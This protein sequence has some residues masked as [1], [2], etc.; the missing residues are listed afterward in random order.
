MMRLQITFH[1]SY[2]N[3]R[4]QEHILM[5]K[6]TLITRPFIFFCANDP[7]RH[8]CSTAN[9]ELC[10]SNIKVGAFVLQSL[11]ETW[12]H[13][14][15]LLTKVLEVPPTE[16]EDHNKLL[17]VAYKTWNF[18]RRNRIKTI[19]DTLLL[20]QC[21]GKFGLGRYS[22]DFKNQWFWRWVETLEPLKSDLQRTVQAKKQPEIVKAETL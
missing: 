2:V 19:L 15:N 6:D 20:S 22:G 10:R 14:D 1:A 4:S 3:C 9:L 5:S 21:N 13:M 18:F 12:L 11:T 16:L 17:L 8:Q 7:Q